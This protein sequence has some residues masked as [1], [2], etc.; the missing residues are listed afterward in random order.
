MKK[1]LVGI[2]IALVLAVSCA[3][4]SRADSG[5]FPVSV[6]MPAASAVSFTA[7]EILVNDPDDLNDDTWVTGSHPTSLVFG[8]LVWNAAYSIFRPERYFAI[9]LGASQGGGTVTNISFSYT[10]G[11]NPNAGTGRGGLDKKATLKVVKAVYKSADV[12]VSALTELGSV[13]T[14]GT[15]TNTSFTGG[16]P[17][18]YVGINDGADVNLGEPF[19]VQDVDGPYS[20]TLMISAS[21][22]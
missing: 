8:T 20:G 4:V 21:L 7:S 13:A 9:D 5:S 2:T 11:N 1:T 18:V 19:T 3:G 10:Q 15:F 22:L 16:W 6:V 17:R 12:A 14:L